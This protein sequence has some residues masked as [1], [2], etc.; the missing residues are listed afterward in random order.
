MELKNFTPRT[1]QEKILSTAVNANTLA[2]LP[3]GMGKTAIAILLAI[4]RLK[5]YPQGKILL[6]SPTKPLCNQHIQTFLDYTTL[7]TH[8]IALL[9]GILQPKIR[10]ELWEKAKVIIATPQT[11]ESDLRNNRISLKDV[12]VLCID[13]AHH[14][15]MRYAN[16]G[17]ALY[18]KE[19]AI[20]PRILALT[21]SPGFTKEK[22]NEICDNLFIERV[23]IRTE[24][25]EDVKPYIQEKQTEWMYVELPESMKQLKVFLDASYKEKLQ[26]LREIGLTKPL[27]IVNKR[28]L[29]QMQIHFQREIANKNQTA[30][31]GISMV[32][33]AI[34]V[35][36]ALTLLETQGIRSLH[37]YLKKLQSE[38]TRAAKTLIK[39][40]NIAQTIAGTQKLLD[41]NVQHPKL[42]KLK[43]II[44]EELQKNPLTKFIIFANYRLTVNEVFHALQEEPLAKP[45][46]LVGQKEGLT[47]KQQA[48]VIIE[49]TEGKYNI[50]V[51]TSITEEGLDIPG[52]AELAIFFEPVPSEIR[53]IQRKGRVGRIKVGKV[54]FLITK[55][56]K[57]EAFYWSSVR[58]E[59]KMKKILYGMQKSQKTLKGF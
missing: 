35:E 6:C 28:D 30:F 55:G 16:T 42:M 17:L 22:I 44:R 37:E 32:A 8:D 3:T 20:N 56:T 31:Y 47:Q 53:S 12:I 15:R 21:A 41:D 26:K 51:G 9:T 36:H 38:D 19:Q 40:R 2:V 29:L 34:K 27:N 58:K 48:Q 54:L 24:E 18:Y 1:Y 4:A 39:E 45:T 14:S 7:E 10:V 52:G 57:D 33:Q 50:I 25:D 43:E 59:N 46:I 13:E 49:F 23:E 11:I 5:D